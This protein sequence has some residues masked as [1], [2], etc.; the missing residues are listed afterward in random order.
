MKFVSVRSAV[1]PLN[2]AAVTSFCAVVVRRRWRGRNVGES[3]RVKVAVT[4][5]DPKMRTGRH[6]S[7]T[8]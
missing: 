7:S 3:K 1:S 6:Q 2:A 8:L 4:H 5:V